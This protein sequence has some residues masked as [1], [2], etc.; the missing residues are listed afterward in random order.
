MRPGMKLNL[1]SLVL[2][3]SVASL[4]LLAGCAADTSS[5]ATDDDASELADTTEDAITGAPSSFGYFVVTRRDNRKCVSPLCGGYFVKR[6][7]QATTRCADGTLQA[8][9]YVSA[10]ELKNVGLSAREEE[11]LLGSLAEGHAVI[12]ALQY[13]KKFN[14]TTLGLLK[15]N[16]GWV[17]ATGSAVDGSFYRAAD[18]GLRCIKAPCPSTTAFQLNGRE[19]HNIIKVNLASTAIPASQESLDRAGQALGTAE[20]VLVA[21]GVALPKCLPG[22]NCGPFLIAQE[23]FL[24]VTRREDR[25][26]GGRGT[27]SC[28][29]GQFCKWQPKDICGAADAGGRCQYKP[30][31]CPQVFLPVCGCDGKTYGNDCTA[32]GAGMSVASAG[33]CKK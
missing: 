3:L 1:V 5:E 30:D 23:F 6:V 14:G 2:S 29:A 20:G 33:A 17:G 26:C 31:F 8:E 4:P 7:N 19:D 24:R 12:K 11:G 16:E 18:N 15:A 9:C 22:S 27:S 13:K 10:I 21:G 32:A 28:N 25:G